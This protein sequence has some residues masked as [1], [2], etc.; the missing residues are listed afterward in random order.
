MC[1]ETRSLILN[2]VNVIAMDSPTLKRQ[3]IFTTALLVFMAYMFSQKN[4]D[5]K[6]R[7]KRI[8]MNSPLNLLI[9]ILQII[10]LNCLNKVKFLQI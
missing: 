2:H 7:V 4:E 3:V 10:P 1:V 5:Y 8:Y 9:E 6:W